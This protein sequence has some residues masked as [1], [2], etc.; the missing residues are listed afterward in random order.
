MLQQVTII[1]YL[2]GSRALR[3]SYFAG[4]F[5]GNVRHL[6]SSGRSCRPA[7]KVTCSN[8]LP[9]QS[10]PGR[11]LTLSWF[12]IPY[13]LLCYSL[14]LRI[15]KIRYQIF[16]EILNKSRIGIRDTLKKKNHETVILSGEV[17]I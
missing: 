11:A 14:F 3:F 7:V 17:I 12:F 8:K 13:F 15:L 4:S 10:L 1:F 9:L 6:A 2:A 5:S 16:L